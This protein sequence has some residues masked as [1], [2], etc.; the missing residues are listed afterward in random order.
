MR[1]SRL[2]S[3]E[4][5]RA[6][7]ATVIAASCAGCDKLV[8]I[9]PA[10]EAVEV[11]LFDGP[12]YLCQWVVPFGDASTTIGGIAIDDDGTVWMAGSFEG[13]LSVAGGAP[14]KAAGAGRDAFVAHLA[15][16]GNH[17]WS[18][19]FGNAENDSG[20]HAHRATAIALGDAAV[21]VAGDFTGSLSFGAACELPAGAAGDGAFVARL[22][23][24]DPS[25]GNPTCVTYGQRGAD[26][27]HALA[28]DRDRVVILT[29]HREGAELELS[30][31]DGQTLTRPCRG[32]LRGAASLAF[33]PRGL[34]ASSGEA[35]L[36]SEF[37]GRGNLGLG[38][39]RH[40]LPPSARRASG[41]DSF[42]AAFRY[43]DGCDGVHEEG[44]APW[45]FHYGGRPGDQRARAVALHAGGIVVA[46]TF[47]GEIGFTG[48]PE[49]GITSSG[50][51]SFIVRLERSGS[52]RWATHLGGEMAQSAAIIESDAQGGVIVAGS[53]QKEITIGGEVYLTG[54]PDEGDIFL[55]R[56]GAERGDIEWIGGFNGAGAQEVLAAA[57]SGT[58][59]YLAGAFT[60]DFKLLN[61][62][63]HVKDGQR[64]VARLS[65]STH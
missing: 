48:D 22:D 26:R 38:S 23:K 27:A 55:A 46:G 29:S 60:D 6:L 65:L 47:D 56:L 61:C 11:P 58:D 28:L 20:V 34:R 45:I 30:T 57:V 64:F 25:G 8:G 9:R 53:F 12:G 37:E 16:D 62:P 54:W 3:H 13:D 33:S 15:R 49:V 7:V 5:T 32:V 21:Y 40:E 43:D 44:T 10:E 42:L 41:I 17:L 1:P 18:A 59:V 35:F 50:E 24:D 4:A 2:L 19:R 51:D 63:L 14:L 31:Y 36:V 52:F 39:S